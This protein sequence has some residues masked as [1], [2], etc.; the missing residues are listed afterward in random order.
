M[1]TPKLMKL[2]C[3]CT[4][5]SWALACQMCSH[6]TWLVCL[7]AEIPMPREDMALSGSTWCGQVDGERAVLEALFT[8]PPR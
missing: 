8:W 3:T 7:A 4:L 1:S 2:A 5:G 6:G